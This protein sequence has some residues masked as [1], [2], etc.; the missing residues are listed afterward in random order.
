MFPSKEQA[1]GTVKKK[2]KKVVSIPAQLLQAVVS[3]TQGQV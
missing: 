3:G 2:K 1:L